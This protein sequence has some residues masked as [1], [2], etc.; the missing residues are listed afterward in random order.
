MV[1]VRPDWRPFTTGG[2]GRPKPKYRGRGRVRATRGEWTKLRAERLEGW[3]CRICFERPADG[4]HHVVPR[5]LGGDDVAANLVALCGSGTTGCHGLV[6][7]RDR[8]A[9]HTLAVTVQAEDM[10]YAYCIDRLGEGALH[11]LFGVYEDRQ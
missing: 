2:I 4:L 6:E 10:V 5:S 9:L 11:R 7:H 3:L 1:D 8:E